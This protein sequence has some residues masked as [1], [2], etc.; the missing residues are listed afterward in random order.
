MNNPRVSRTWRIRH[1]SAI[2]R[3]IPPR[4]VRIYKEGALYTVSTMYCMGVLLG[5]D[6]AGLGTV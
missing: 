6:G 5:L 1:H 4:F 2:I 3:E